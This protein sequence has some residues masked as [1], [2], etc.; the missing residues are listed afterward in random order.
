MAGAMRHEQPMNNTLTW[1]GERLDMCWDDHAHARREN[2][3]PDV[4]CSWAGLVV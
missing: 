4:V 3:L 1:G 2:G